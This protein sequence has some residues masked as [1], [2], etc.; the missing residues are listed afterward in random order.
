[1]STGNVHSNN[2][3][4]GAKTPTGTQQETPPLKLEIPATPVYGA[5]TSLNTIENTGTA[6]RD[7]GGG[8]N[9]LNWDSL[10][11]VDIG[12]SKL[13]L[14]RLIVNRPEF[15]DEGSLLIAANTN[16][17]LLQAT[18]RQGEDASSDDNLNDVASSTGHRLSSEFSG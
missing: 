8:V 4:G 15:Q 13:A 10:F 11:Y 14:K 6:G 2:G 3:N 17:Q 1:M 7:G 5:L 12:L 16:Q 18:G 9:Q